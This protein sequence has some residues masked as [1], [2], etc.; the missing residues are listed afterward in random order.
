MA[1]LKDT[2]R[3]TF[4]ELEGLE[5]AQQWSGLRPST[6]KGPPLLGRTK[7]KNLWSNIGQ[8]SLGFTLAA[9]SAMVLAQL[10]GQSTSPIQLDGLTL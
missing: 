9:G 8:G 4:P 5:S 6:P 10:I 1:A 2:V 3:K 7:Y